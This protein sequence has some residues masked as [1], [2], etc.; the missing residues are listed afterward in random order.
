DEFPD[1]CAERDPPPMSTLYRPPAPRPKTPIR[2]LVRV[3]RQGE[4]NLLGL[5]PVDAYEKPVTYLGYSRRSILLVNSPEL[6]R[7]ILTD[8]LGIFP[9]ND[10]MTGALAPLVGDSIFVSSGERWRRQRAMIDPAF[11][12]MRINHAFA[13]MAAAV[14][15]YEALLEQRAE[16]GEWFSLDLA[17]SHLTADVICRTIF[18]TP[19]S[20]DTVQDVF[21]AFTEFER[22][23]ASVNLWQLIFGK[24][25]ADVKQPARVLDACERIRRQIGRFVDPRLAPDA[26]RI[27]DIVSALIDARDADSGEGF[28][29]EELIDQ[30]GVLFLAG[31]ETTASVM[32]W[33]FFILAVRPDVGAR[34]REEIAAV[35]G[36][37]PVTFNQVK[38]LSYV[39][40]V[41]REALRLY[42][43]IT[44]IPRVAAE[45]TQIGDYRVKRGAMIMISPWTAHRN[46][47]LWDNADRFD[48]DRFAKARE[49]EARGAFMSFGL[50]PR[51]CVGAAF[52]T[53]ESGLILARLV[54]RFDIDIAE[55]DAVRPVARLTTR[56]AQEIQCRVRRRVQ[57]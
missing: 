35:A 5:V 28:T 7:N 37:G 46:A 15:D 27:D 25:W 14:D 40:N 23:V 32:T 57:Q 50:G 10:L 2:S 21:D 31:H 55:P 36:D 11:S 45:A 54:R 38:R 47:A 44:F 16:S 18:S 29:R 30:I 42:P 34:M 39:R 6:A 19:L 22:S 17:M 41:F 33:I 48:P 52:A 43:P 53:V 56:P 4:G 1:G 24:P 8:P 51:V 26:P 49:N 12:H 3:I 13:S 20:S 9:K